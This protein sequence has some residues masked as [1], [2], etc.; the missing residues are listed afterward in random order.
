MRGA[1]TPPRRVAARLVPWT[2]VGRTERISQRKRGGER[3][4]KKEKTA[5]RCLF[6]VLFKNIYYYYDAFASLLNK[7]RLSFIG[8][9]R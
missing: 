3:K 2:V 9:L 7:E 8:K 5:L 1:E 4:K 6:V